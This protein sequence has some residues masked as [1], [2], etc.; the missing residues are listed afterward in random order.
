MDVIR[1]S[2]NETCLLANR[3]LW[4][5]ARPRRRRLK[6]DSGAAFKTCLLAFVLLL[7][8]WDHDALRGACCRF[9]GLAVSGRR[10]SGELQRTLLRHGRYPAS[11][12]R[13]LVLW[14]VPVRCGV[15][16][17]W[18]LAWP[19]LPAVCPFAQRETVRKLSRR[20]AAQR[21]CHVVHLS[22]IRDSGKSPPSAH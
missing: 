19:C 9:H 11:R 17:A 4:R 18:R 22:K 2:N 16:H 3:Q 15:S 20:I 13:C 10:N 8:S 5:V 21:A 14:A 6:P 12:S 1:L 7:F